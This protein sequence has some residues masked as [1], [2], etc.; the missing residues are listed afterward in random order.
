MLEWYR[1]AKMTLREESKLL[2]ATKHYQIAKVVKEIAPDM[3]ERY[4]ERELMRITV[5]MSGVYFDVSVHKQ[6]VAAQA[7]RWMI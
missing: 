6:A 5:S 7:E 4:T 2:A 3:L 1:T